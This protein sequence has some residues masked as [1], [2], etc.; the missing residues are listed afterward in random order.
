MSKTLQQLSI[1]T[2]GASLVTLGVGLG[3]QAEAATL[4]G[5]RTT[6]ENNL[7]SIIVDDYSNPGYLVGGNPASS[8]VIHNDAYMSSVVG[9]TKY[10]ATGFSNTNIILKYL[11]NA[12]CA[13]CNGSFL[14]DFTETS[15]GTAAGVFGAGFDITDATQ[16]FAHVTFGDNTTQDYSLANK[17][18][19]GLTSDKS[20]KS[21]HVGL[22]N[23]GTTQNGYISIDKLTIGATSVPEPTTMLGILGM[24]A[25]GTT[26][27]LKRNKV[28]KA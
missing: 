18:F 24:A 2:L 1:A 10:T 7:S 25:V 14:L 6:F 21:V 28:N 4:F 20:I 8:I 12:Y 19:W 16:Y 13:G 9:E 17:T 23:G 15:I 5:D 27:L 22:Q 11:N 3:Q 26:S